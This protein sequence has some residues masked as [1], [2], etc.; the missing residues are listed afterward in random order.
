MNAQRATKAAA[1][2][3]IIGLVG[4]LLAVVRPSIGKT[5]KVRKLKEIG[6]L[7][8]VT[9]H[10]P[11]AGDRHKKNIER[12]DPRLAHQGLNF[13]NFENHPRALL[14][15]MDGRQ[16]HAWDAGKLRFSHA[17]LLPNG[18]VL[19]VSQEQGRVFKLDLRSRIKWVT[20]IKG[21]HDLD[22][23]PRGEI[24]VLTEGG[25]RLPR[26]HKTRPTVENWIQVLSPQ[27][28]TRRRLALSRLLL[29]SGL[30][31]DKINELM[32]KNVDDEAD[33]HDAFHANTVELIRQDVF[34]GERRLFS[35]GQLL[36]CIRNLNLIC[37]VDPRTEKIVWSWGTD[38]LDR[39]HQPTMLD[40]GNILIL[41]NGYFRRYSRVVEVD[42][43]RGTI[44][45]QYKANP[46]EDFFTSLS[47]GCQGL[48]NGNVLVTES[49]TGRVFEITREGQNVWEYHS[50]LF[51]KKK[52]RKSIWRMT[53]Y[54]DD[55]RFP[56]LERFRTLQ[57]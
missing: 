34:D 27:G 10:T 35:R 28:Q 51:N 49:M 15:D 5:A 53:R 17:E 14:I 21:H 39:P 1:V 18:D 31:M 50:P 43:R 40:S 11:A 23:G 4:V 32:G 12:H 25:A 48:S 41:D 13:F 57:Q 6:S 16:L 19:G 56:V 47:G 33:G 54:A 55:D 37:V 8:Y 26:F 24:Y 46:T 9:W 29:S 36:I 20:K 22:V 38:Q 44:N 3:G 30:S 52:E 7:P 42:P 45:W 2:V